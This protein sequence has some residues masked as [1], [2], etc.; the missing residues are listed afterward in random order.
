MLKANVK[1]APSL[2]NIVIVFL[3]KHIAFKIPN[4]SENMHF[5]NYIH[6]AEVINELNIPPSQKNI[7][8]YYSVNCP[9]H[10]M[11][12]GT[13][14]KTINVEYYVIRKGSALYL[15]LQNNKKWD[16]NYNDMKHPLCELASKIMQCNDTNMFNMYNSYHVLV[17]YIKLNSRKIICNETL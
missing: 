9:R 15:T 10:T 17:Q 2:L 12:V 5:V 13:I 16:K 11:L 8:L 7:L 1:S 14:P 3:H 6:S 4:I